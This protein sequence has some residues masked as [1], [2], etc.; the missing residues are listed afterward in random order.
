MIKKKYRFRGETIQHVS[1]NED[2]QTFNYSGWHDRNMWEPCD[3]F[4]SFFDEFPFDTER[5][6]IAA[7]LNQ[8]NKERKEIEDLIE[9]LTLRQYY[10][11][12]SN[13]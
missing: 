6:C 10:G 1:I 4:P 12:Y 11:M 7:F 13:D 3:H 2:N 5:D 9:Q 8:L